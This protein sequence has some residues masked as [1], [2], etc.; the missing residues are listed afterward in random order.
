MPRRYPSHS[1][2]VSNPVGSPSMANRVFTLGPRKS[3]GHLDQLVMRSQVPSCAWVQ[4]YCEPPVFGEAPSAAH[5]SWV[6]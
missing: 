2:S 5:A 1:F 4:V 3:G 6:A